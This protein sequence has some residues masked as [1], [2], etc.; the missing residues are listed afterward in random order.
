M[1][2]DDTLGMGRPGPEVRGRGAA[3]AV[4]Y[5]LP[6]LSLTSTPVVVYNSERGGA[7]PPPKNRP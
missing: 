2:V 5:S 4:T 7:E 1:V 3:R 6:S